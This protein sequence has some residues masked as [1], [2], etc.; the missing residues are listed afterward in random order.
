[1]NFIQKI[2]LGLI[3]VCFSGCATLDT[4]M[5]DWVTPT[6]DAYAKQSTL[7]QNEKLSSSSQSSAYSSSQQN[8]SQNF[9]RSAENTR[10]KSA[11]K[12]ALSRKG[13]AEAKRCTSTRRA[14]SAGTDNLLHIKNNCRQTVNYSWCYA[15][16][17]DNSRLNIHKCDSGGRY[18]FN[19]S[20]FVR[21][22]DENWFQSSQGAQ[23]RLGV[24]MKD[25][26]LDGKTYG[27]INTER[28]GDN[29]YSCN[30]STYGR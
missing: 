16:L 6:L 3:S 5:E 4:F 7:E 28:T 22:F 8:A 19:G 1:V 20:N 10:S 26:V 21:P 18:G 13:G 12:G 9:D 29:Q 30:Y 17:T 14:R 2:S 11:L 15:R 25:V 24:C 27:H 23:V